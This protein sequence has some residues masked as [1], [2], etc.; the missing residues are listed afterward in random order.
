MEASLGCGTWHK[1]REVTFNNDT[2]LM[3]TT[4]LYQQ[5]QQQQQQKFQ[6]LRKRWRQQGS[7]RA[8]A[9]AVD[10]HALPSNNGQTREGG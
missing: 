9:N 5:Q 2:T 4:T 3:R 6:Y 8:K 7:S 1:E 10:Y